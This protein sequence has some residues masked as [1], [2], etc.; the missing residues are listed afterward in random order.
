MDGPGHRQGEGGSA[1]FSNGELAAAEE[2]AVGLL[3]AFRDQQFASAKRLDMTARVLTASAWVLL[4]FGIAA[5]F[6]VGLVFIENVGTASGLGA[7]LAVWVGSAILFLPAY[8]TPTWARAYAT[9]SL[10][11]VQLSWL[12]DM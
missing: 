4:G 5:G 2:Q 7:M 3:R 8:L 1:Q 6:V 9:K 12:R 11:E 10:S